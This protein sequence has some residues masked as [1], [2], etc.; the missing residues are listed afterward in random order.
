MLVGGLYLKFLDVLDAAAV[1]AVE[2]H[3]GGVVLH[4]A[5]CAGGV[6]FGLLLELGT[7]GLVVF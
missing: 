2:L 7:S 3:A 5:V 6:E 4:F 1:Q